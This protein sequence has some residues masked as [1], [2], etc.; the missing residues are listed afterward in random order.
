MLFLIVEA[1][2][3]VTGILMCVSLESVG[4]LFSASSL[5]LHIQLASYVISYLATNVNIKPC[6]VTW[7]VHFY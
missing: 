1:P 4:V 7:R 6:E 5:A 2:V 3:P